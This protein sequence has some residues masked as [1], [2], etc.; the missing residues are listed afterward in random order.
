M[1]RAERITPAAVAPL[2]APPGPPP[3]THHEI[4]R[5]AEP[6]S[7]AG[8]SVDLAATD[9]LARQL[10]FRP[11]AH[12]AVAEMPA[13]RESLLLDA[14]DD[15]WLSLQ[16]SLSAVAGVDADAG[17][18][19]AAGADSAGALPASPPGPPS[20]LADAAFGL[21]ASLQAEGAAPAQLLAWVD[22]LPP[23]RQW[24]QAAGVRIALSHKL[25]PPS[26]GQAEPVLTLVQASARLAGLAIVMKVSRV[27]NVPA[28]LELR[29][30]SAAAGSPGSPGPAAM[31]RARAQPAPTTLPEDLLSVLGLD[32]SRLSRHSAGWRA[33]LRLRGEGMARALDAEA[34]FRRSIEHL[35]QVL[36]AAPAAFHPQYRAARWRVSLRRGFPL[37]VCLLLI[38]ASAAVPLLEL[39]PGSVYRMLIFNAPPL[40]MVWL[41]AMRELPRIELPPLPRALPADAWAAQAAGAAAPMPAEAGQDRP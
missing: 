33:T 18:G 13:V 36:G 39:G 35:V 16:R 38:A 10:A 30:L 9:R 27:K 17:A 23:Q 25:Q 6:F 28:E 15:G 3:L 8:R 19:T 11:R 5:L 20:A 12:A 2:S 24:Q 40:L 1:L 26:R 7:R 37:L 31:G 41:F 34:K 32:W 29:P 21:H 22:A 4:L 14:A